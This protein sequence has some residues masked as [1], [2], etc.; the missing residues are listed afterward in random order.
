MSEKNLQILKE[1]LG[2][3]DISVKS[4]GTDVTNK[5]EDAGHSSDSRDGR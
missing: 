5:F 1:H 3:Y 2:G 4:V